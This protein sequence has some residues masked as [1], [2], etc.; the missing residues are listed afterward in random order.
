HLHP[1]LVTPYHAWHSRDPDLSHLHVF[2]TRAYVHN[3]RACGGK[4]APT[5]W[6]GYLVGYSSHSTGYC[7][8]K[9]HT[10]RILNIFH[11]AFIEDHHHPP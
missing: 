1:Q 9:P 10:N 2:C 6:E 3:D 7:I 11:V 5:A 4:L 8:W